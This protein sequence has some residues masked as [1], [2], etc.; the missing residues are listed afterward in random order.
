MGQQQYFL[1]PNYL[2]DS[3]SQ[4]Q[5]RRKAREGRADTASSIL[6]P[7]TGIIS[8]AS[9][10]YRVIYVTKNG[11][12]V[13]IQELPRVLEVDLDHPVFRYIDRQ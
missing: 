12:I 9:S 8:I 1:L 4:A 6:H 10:T 2:G 13:N 7:S 3:G 5:V 11:V